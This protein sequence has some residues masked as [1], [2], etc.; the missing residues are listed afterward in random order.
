MITITNNYFQDLN[1][2]IAAGII[3]KAGGKNPKKADLY[4]AIAAHNE[5]IETPQTEVEPVDMVTST[6][7]EIVT[8]EAEGDEAALQAAL[9]AMDAAEDAAIA[10]QQA[11][12]K[13]KQF[14][15]PKELYAAPTGNKPVKPGSKV[16][17]EINTLRNGATKEELLTALGWNSWSHSRSSALAC[18][19][20][21]RRDVQGKYWL[22]EPQAVAS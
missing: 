6:Q 2:A 12:A 15:Q 14:R 1:A 9:M 19:Y 5:T 10:E 16:E 18:G 4:A 17:L 3:T 8:L 13:V 20:G 7:A 22:V 21:I 11:Q